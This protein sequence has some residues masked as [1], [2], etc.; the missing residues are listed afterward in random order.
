MAPHLCDNITTITRTAKNSASATTH[1]VGSPFAARGA[2]R[3]IAQS[4]RTSRAVTLGF[5]TRS[6][7]AWIDFRASSAITERR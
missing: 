4:S 3:K 6:C 2:A 7:Q 1:A 5:L